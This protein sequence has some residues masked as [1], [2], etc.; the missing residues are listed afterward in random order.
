[1]PCV[2]K[3]RKK[4]R[5]MKDTLIAFTHDTV[6]QKRYDAG[7]MQRTGVPRAIQNIQEHLRMYLIVPYFFFFLLR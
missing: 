6:L 7:G 1:M 5:I 2:K 3:W 4:W